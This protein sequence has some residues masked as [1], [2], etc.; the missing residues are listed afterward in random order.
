MNHP[1]NIIIVGGGPAGLNAALILGRCRRRVLLYDSCKPRNA[2]SKSMH[3]F[4]SRDGIAP[5]EFLALGRDQLRKYLSV[6][7][8]DLEV[9][10]A[11]RAGK[12]F[13]LIQ[14]DSSQSQCRKLILATGLIHNLPDVPGMKDLYGKS[15]FLCPFCDGWEIRDEPLAIYGHGR[16]SI[17]LALEL[18]LWRKG[19]VFCTG[20]EP[21]M[22]LGLRHPRTLYRRK[23]IHLSHAVEH[24][25]RRRGSRGGVC[26]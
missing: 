2:V 10:G 7:V 17:D 22:D 6:T 16:E 12:D 8:R 20:G 5:H 1:W 14:S 15:V 4:L 26:R 11:R 24:C 25:G 23:C 21:M 3:G 9:V 13:E 18:T 19:L